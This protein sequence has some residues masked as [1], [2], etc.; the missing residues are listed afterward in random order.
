M[1]VENN[2]NLLH[3]FTSILQ[4]VHYSINDEKNK[5]QTVNRYSG[6]LGYFVTKVARGNLL[7]IVG[8]NTTTIFVVIVLHLNLK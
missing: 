3:G 6:E 2:I 7:A 1:K 8:K 4:K 5:Y